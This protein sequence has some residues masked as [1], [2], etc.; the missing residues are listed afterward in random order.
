MNNTLNYSEMFDLP[1]NIK[2]I[3]QLT[4]AEIIGKYCDHFGDLMFKI[5]IYIIG[6]CLLLIIAYYVCNRYE[7]YKLFEYIIIGSL[8][9]IIAFTVIMI[10]V[11]ATQYPD[12][13]I[14]RYVLR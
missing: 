11:S 9:A 1:L 8:F 10:V 3:S 4:D 6:I 2:P 7:K 13:L 12:T 14:G 5:P